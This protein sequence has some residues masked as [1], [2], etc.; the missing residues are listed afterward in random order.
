MSQ[1]EQLDVG[2]HY[3]VPASVYHSDPAPTPSLSSSIARVIL[4][5]SLCHAAHD[6]PRLSKT[7]GRKPTKAMR[8]GSA[9][10]AIQSGDETDIVVG[11]FDDF[12]KNV[13]KDWRDS[14]IESGR[15]P[16]LRHELEGKIRPMVDALVSKV[17]I[18]C[19]SPFV[20]HGRD[21][22]T[23]IWKE[24]E[25][26]CRAR[27]DR[28]VVDP[29]GFTADIWDWKTTTDVSA[30]ALNRKIVDEGYHIQAAFYLRGLRSLMPSLG[31][32]ASFV[33]GFVESDAP[34]AVSRVCLS[35]GFLDIGER[36]VSRAIALWQ[37]ASAARR[38]PEASEGQTVKLMPPDWYVRK[39]EEACA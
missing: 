37:Q 13:A 27:F 5:Q 17:A 20:S 14:I 22:V 3:N 9:V 30:E 2:L 21:E 33:F 34:H 12:K 39:F 16:I 38:W 4:S 28:L 18:G 36:A 19:D 11:E 31:G 23:A 26:Y 7:K 24:G 25:I 1:T 29:M 35:E 15:T 8:F 6:H 32:R 10:H